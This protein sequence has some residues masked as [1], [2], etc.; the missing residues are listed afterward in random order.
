MEI[1]L[2]TLESDMNRIMRGRDDFAHFPDEYIIRAARF[3]LGCDLSSTIGLKKARAPNRN[4][5]LG[6]LRLCSATTAAAPAKDLGL[7]SDLSN[8]PS[9]TQSQTG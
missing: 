5:M 3:L 1:R 2:R 7:F 4:I 8:P 9:H 6:N